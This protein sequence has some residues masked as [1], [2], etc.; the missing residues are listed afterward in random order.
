MTRGEKLKYFFGRVMV[1]HWGKRG[2]VTRGHVASV[3]DPPCADSARRLDG[4]AVLSKRVAPI[5]PR[6]GRDDQHLRSTLESVPQ[7]FW[8]IEVALTDP[9]AVRLQIG[10]LLHI[11][12][13]SAHLVPGTR[14]TSFSMIARP[15]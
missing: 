7:A 8:I 11:A 6:V 1:E 10:G 3:D 2:G 14:S 5:C 15:R 9:D 4:R 12:D 13:A